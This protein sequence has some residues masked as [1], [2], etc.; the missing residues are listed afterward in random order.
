MEKEEITHLETM[1]S[2]HKKNLY[3][4]EE[5]LAKYGT[6]QPLHLINSV[7]MEREAIARYSKQIE[8][9]TSTSKEL[10]RSTALASLP[11]RPYFVGRDEEIKAI[12]QSLQPNSRTFIIGIEG[13]GG[14]GKSTL[15]IELSHRCIENDL[16]EAVIWISAKESILTLHGIEPVIPEAKTLSDILITIGTSLGNPTIGNLSIQDQIKRA[17]NLLSRRTTL[18]VLDNFESLSKNEQRDIVD[19]LRRSPMT[20]KVVITSRERV[21]EGQVIRLQG[22]SFEESNA[23]LDWDAQQKNIHLT[24]DQSKYLVDL[25]GGLPLALLWVQGQIAVLGYS[26]TQVLDKLSLDA[27]IPILQ[28]CFNHSWNLLGESDAKKLLFILALQPEAVSRAALQEIAGIDDNERFDHAIS[29]LLQLSLI[30]HEHD[31]DYFSILPLTR[32][33]IRTQFTSGRKFIKQ[34]E[35]K[36][37]QYYVKFLEQKSSF[38]EWRGYDD[39]LVD[40]NNILSVAQWCY[41]SVQK[42]QTSSNS[43]AKQTK[44]IAEILVQIGIHFGSVLWQRAY[45]YDRMTLAH[46]ALNVAK[47]I[48]DW[49][50][51]STFARNISWIYF[52]QGD[53]LRALH[54]AEE[55]LSAT[56][57]TEDELLIAAAKRSLGTVELRLGN[58]DRSE[59]LLKDVLITSEAFAS[60]DYGIYSKGFAQYGLGDLEF[61]RGNISRA[62]E[63][64]QKALDTWQDPVR[65]DPVRHISYALNGLGF[66]AL[67]EKRYPEA[68]R[69]FMEGVQS[70][71]EFGRVDELAKGQLGLAS[72]HLDTGSDLRTALTLVNESIES[73]QQQGMQYQI[74]KGQALRDDILKAQSQ[75][76][77]PQ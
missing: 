25:T 4:L 9:L 44:N 37:A 23:L 19:F 59:K 77:T 67:R 54:W 33:Y 63:W 64:Y 51:V 50:S 24:K 18:L 21:S 34:A 47:L 70:A 71:E 39:L 13:I 7:T 35:L 2:L 11:R 73:F 48:E 68:K 28:Y 29:H 5:M 72:V 56:T 49:K 57:K 55:S 27:D 42:K 30:E 14:M 52:Y 61:E 12:L 76:T 46:A 58:F 15:A 36:T 8:G 17:Y 66:V 22:L 10:E 20:L 74:Q 38:K 16:F 31:K 69:F 3:I 1:I 26:V 62:K 32:R 45:W 40:R 60:D 53:Y 75:T 41:K 43:L 6:D 65:K